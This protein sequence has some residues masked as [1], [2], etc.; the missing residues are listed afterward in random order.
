M[1]ISVYLLFLWF[2]MV[3]VVREHGENCWTLMANPILIGVILIMT[4]ER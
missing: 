1:L 4:V 3:L 2:K